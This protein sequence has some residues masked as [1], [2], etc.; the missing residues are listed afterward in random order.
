MLVKKRLTNT[1]SDQAA[2][3]G[4]G[5]IAKPRFTFAGTELGNVIKQ[6]N[7]AYG[8]NVVTRGN[9]PR[10]YGLR[11]RTGIFALDLSLGGGFLMSRGSMIY[12]EK[13][14]GKTTTAMMCAVCCQRMF[15]DKVVVWVDIEGTFD[16]D[17]F[18]KMGGDLERLVIVEPETGEQAVDIADGLVRS[19]ETSMLVTDSI[20][21]LTPMKEIQQSSEDKIMGG[22][23]ILIGNY[24]RRVNNA[25]LVERHRNHRPL[26]L[27]INQ[28][29]SK[30]GLVFGDPRTLPGGKA[31]EFCTTQQV[32]I[33]NKEHITDKGDI[34]FNEHTFKITKDKTGGRIRE[35]KFKLVRDPDAFKPRLPEG[36]IDQIR[37][38][39]DFG[40]RV[41]FVEGQYSIQGHG[42]F[43]SADIAQEYFLSRQD[44]YEQ[45]QIDIITAF[46]K[47]W[48]LSVP[49]NA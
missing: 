16:H 33:K 7:D 19:L 11:A 46:R 14:A 25:F 27:H 3:P 38:I 1:P 36:Y 37:T 40:S 5:V 15:P 13:S 12:G 49:E 39:L 20:A 31:L 23:S 45:L 8:A 32:E 35:G 21:M 22:N 48:G 44:A 28:F 47:S 43:K 24:L 9:A 29:R 30:V 6:A 18:V 34:Q 17:W 42:K 4:G 2:G 41:G 10:P 26:V